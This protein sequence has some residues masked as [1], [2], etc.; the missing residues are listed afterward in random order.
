MHPDTII[1][2]V[3]VGLIIGAVARLV[4]PGR[5]PIGVLLTIAVGLIGAFGGLFIG[6]GLNLHR[7]LIFVLQVVIAALLVSLFAGARARSRSYT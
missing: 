5:Q 3:V 1:G 4:L 7:V 2:A 6:A